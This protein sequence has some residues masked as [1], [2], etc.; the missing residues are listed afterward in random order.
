MV[1]LAG[2]ALDFGARTGVGSCDVA[3]VEGRGQEGADVVEQRLDAFVLERRAADHRHDSH[4][5]G[6]D[7]GAADDVVL[8]ERVG[9]VE[10]LHCDFVVELGNVVDELVV[11]FTGF[12]LEGLG[13]F[14]DAVVGSEGLVVPV[15]GLHSDEVDDALERFLGSDGDDH[16]TGVGVKDVA[17]LAEDTIVIGSVAVHLVD[18]GNTGHVVLVGLTPDGLTL[19]FD[20]SDGAEGGDG[21]VENAQR[22]FHLGGEID[23]SWSVY[24]IDFI[25]ISVPVPMCRGGC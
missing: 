20:A 18:V 5:K 25:L 1:V 4:S 6:A 7:A 8:G 9:V 15:D 16:G 12:G 19:G 23:V 24:Q 22:T 2:V 3:V 11:P 13:D 10:V 14:L 21:S 17:Y